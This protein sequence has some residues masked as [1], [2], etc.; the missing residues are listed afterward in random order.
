MQDIEIISV[1]PLQGSVAQWIRRLPTEQEI[2]GSSPAWVNPFWFRFFIKNLN[3]IIQAID[4]SSFI[5]ADFGKSRELISKI[6]DIKLSSKLLIWFFVP[7][8]L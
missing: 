3:D 5:W 4:D 6:W 1:V 7:W 2:V 8:I